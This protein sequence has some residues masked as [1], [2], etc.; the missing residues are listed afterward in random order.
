MQYLPDTFCGIDMKDTARIMYGME[1]WIRIVRARMKEKGIKQPALARVMNVETR[2]AV[3]HYLTGRR[4]PTHAQFKAMALALGL[5][6]GALFEGRKV[7]LG[8][9]DEVFVTQ[10]VNALETRLLPKL[11]PAP[12]D[13]PQAQDQLSKARR[14]K[15]SAHG[16]P[17]PK[18]PAA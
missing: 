14:R 18:K 10:I 2:G 1:E 16:P 8:G 11:L 3:G 12:Q 7:E 5:Q 13:E 17:G 9:R 4:E 15:R 6:P